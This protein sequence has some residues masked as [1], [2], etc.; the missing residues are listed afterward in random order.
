[1]MTDT[2]KDIKSAVKELYMA[3]IEAIRN[4]STI[5]TNLQKDELKIPGNLK[6]GGTFNYLPTG[7][8]IMWSGS[9]TAI[10]NGWT[11]C[12]GKLGAP[13]LRGR[14][15]LGHG[16]GS[17]LTNRLQGYVGGEENVT[18][19]VAQMPAHGH[20]INAAGNHQHLSFIDRNNTCGCGGGSCSCGGVQQD[21][22][23]SWNG[24]HNHR[25][26][27]TGGSQAHNNMPPFFVLAYIMKT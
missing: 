3:D 11:I 21:A 13:D 10:P 6:V 25:M 22:G 14:F 1:M 15:I 20:Y 17:G 18:L 16:Q 23:T 5:A 9:V 8:V 27:N 26:D 4:L 2:T 12:D 7:C 19:S 24:E